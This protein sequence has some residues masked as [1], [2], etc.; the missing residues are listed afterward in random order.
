M[1]G[2]IYSP[3]SGK[4]SLSFLVSL[5]E[6][7]V[8]M[9]EPT[10]DRVGALSNRSVPRG[11]NIKLALC[12]AFASGGQVFTRGALIR[13]LGQKDG[14]E[15]GRQ[16]ICPFPQEACPVDLPCNTGGTRVLL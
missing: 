12:V 2:V 8:H 10:K 13:Q 15:V 6:C 7:A 14:G 5:T 3:I 1:G 9:L 4:V 16:G 11:Q